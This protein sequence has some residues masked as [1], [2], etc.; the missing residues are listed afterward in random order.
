MDSRSVID[1]SSTAN[2]YVMA[3]VAKMLIAI[4]AVLAVETRLHDLLQP[5][6]VLIS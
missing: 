2:P 4:D 3:E 5:R 1:Q 6:E